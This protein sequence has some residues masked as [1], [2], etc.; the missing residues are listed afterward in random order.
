MCC[1]YG[2]GSY[3]VTSQGGD[4]IA[5]GGLFEYNETT[6]FAMPYY[7]D[8]SP[9]VDSYYS[10]PTPRPTPRATPNHTRRK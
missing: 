2:E 7:P 5:S 10:Y 1:G 8:G 9:S 6:A 3:N 4:V